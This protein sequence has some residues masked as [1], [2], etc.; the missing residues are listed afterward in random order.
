MTRTSAQTGSEGPPDGQ[1]GESPSRGVER[2]IRDRSPRA[3]YQRHRKVIYGVV[4]LILAVTVWEI[5][6]AR[7][8]PLT[9]VSLLSVA[10]AIAARLEAGLFWRDVRATSSAFV[11]G[12]IIASVA[13]ILIG[14]AIATSDVIH[15][16]FQPWVSALYSTPV[17]ALAPLFIVIFGIGITSKI[18]VVVLLAI[19]PVIINT[20]AGIRSTEPPLIEG[21]Y[22]FGATRLDIFRM[23]LIPS[24]VPYV[25]TGLRLAVGRGLIAV[26]V[27]EFFGARAG[28]GHT[29]FQS[30]QRFDTATLFSGVLIL[31]L[32][33]TILISLMQRLERWIAP[34]RDFKVP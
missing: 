1:E 25:I 23:V 30:S 34:W 15:G 31:A 24:A 32:A 26:V 21:A 13:G 11:V 2:A 3:L 27:A 8:S 7:T 4:S 14:L 33:G 28:L 9:F 18:A 20:T 6:A 16:I 12:Y 19:F 17:I 29:I 22:A 10:E 5:A